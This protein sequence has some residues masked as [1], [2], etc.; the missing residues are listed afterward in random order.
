MRGFRHP[1]WRPFRHPWWRPRPRKATFK[2]SHYG[3]KGNLTENIFGAEFFIVLLD[4]VPKSATLY[5]DMGKPRVLLTTVYRR[6]KSDY[7]DYFGANTKT[8]LRLMWPRYISFG[9][10]F[11]K[12][13]LPEV[14]IL[15]YPTWHEY[16][17]KLKEGWDV[18]GFSFY[19]NETGEIIQM[20]EEAR[21]QGVK[22]LWAGNYG[23]LTEGLNKYFDKLFFGY[24][25]QT[26]GEILGKKVETVIH[27]PLFTPTN[28]GPFGFKYK[29]FGVLFT[30]RG[31]AIGCSF[32][33]T[34]LFCPNPRT[35]PLASIERVLNDYK[36][37]GVHEVII[38]DESFGLFKA[39][40]L[41]VIELL[42]EYGIIW[43]AMIRADVL[44]KH[45]PDWSKKGLVGAFIGI[46]SLSQH[47]LDAL[48]KKEKVEIIT[49]L[50]RKTHELKCFIIGYYMIGYE[51][52]T[53]NSIRR[54]LYNLANLRIDLHQLCIITPLPRTPFWYK[55]DMKYG[56]FEKDWRKYDTK[57]LVFNHPHIKP[58]EMEELLAWGCQHLNSTGRYVSCIQRM[59]RRYLMAR[60]AHLF[61]A[62]VQALT[63]DHKDRRSQWF[64]KK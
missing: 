51:T 4:K 27:P 37:R 18:V 49:E 31:C 54:D 56:I 16:L 26:V 2:E 32:C 11:L 64:F 41:A 22:E 62:P 10:R 39:H 7:Y 52:D 6:F 46:E 3:R 59:S 45:L 12:Q 63:F 13:N 8:K 17:K 57:H 28:L 44:L 55:T 36:R 19:L 24:A 61:T 1:W 9:L 33:Q 29:T 60:P 30:Q 53:S 58:E 48:Q 38:L 47:T 21:R 5:P 20:A 42:V 34:P 35:I 40:T 25:E 50:V 14:E 23:A 15:E 43:S